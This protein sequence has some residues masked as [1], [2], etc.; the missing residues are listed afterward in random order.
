MITLR[1]AQRDRLNGEKALAHFELAYARLPRFE[2]RE[3]AKSLFYADGFLRLGVSPYALML[4][5]GLNTGQL[6][7]LKYSATQPRVPAGSGRES[8]RWTSADNNSGMGTQGYTHL[9]AEDSEE[10][11]RE[12]EKDLP[13]AERRALR[14]SPRKEDVEEGRGIPLQTPL[15]DVGHSD[16]RPVKGAF[17][18][19][20]WAG[21]PASLPKPTG[22][23]RVLE[24]DEYSA[25]R[26]AA[27]KANRALREG[28]PNAYVGKQIHET[29]PVKFGGSPADPKNKIALS[30]QE[31]FGATTW[32]DQLLRSL[33]RNRQK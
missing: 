6:D 18:I 5:R 20:N 7:L 4:A 32:W 29:H 14:E 11:R 13:E 1:S 33:Q 9:A 24:G 8:G 21:Y 26:A 30:P 17:S 23:F 19:N 25:A 15:V 28:N 16:T 22:P 10:K 27:N 2:T 3:D 31:H 12:D